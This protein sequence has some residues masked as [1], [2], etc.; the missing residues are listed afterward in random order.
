M[1]IGE[2]NKRKFTQLFTFIAI[3]I[4]IFT[5]YVLLDRTKKLERRIT[6]QESVIE[7][8]DRIISKEGLNENREVKSVSKDT[9]I[10]S[11]DISESAKQNVDMLTN[12]VANTIDSMANTITTLAENYTNS[13]N[14]NSGNSE[15]P[16]YIHNQAVKALDSNYFVID[17]LNYKSNSENK[18][19]IS[20]ESKI[21][22]IAE[23]GFSESKK[24][25]ASE[26]VDNKESEV[27]STEILSPNNYF[28]RLYSEYDREYTDVKIECFVVTRKNDMGCGVS[29][30]IDSVTGMI[31]G[32]KAFGD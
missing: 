19:K 28:T 15:N 26:G 6:E 8:L 17:P 27:I 10:S 1:A 14:A 7:R 18:T 21:K 5:I 4:L 29:I 12:T 13:I 32:G 16:E 3:I 9:T 24:R 23:I 2:N 20:S 25:I 30:Y 22:S 11:N 31:I